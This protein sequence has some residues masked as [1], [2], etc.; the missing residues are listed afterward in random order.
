MS[1]EAERDAA[2]ARDGYACQVCGRPATQTAH[3]IPN[4]A[5]YRRL[6][7][8]RIIDSRHNLKAACSLVCNAALQV[9][10][11]GPVALAR[12]VARIEAALK[13]DGNDKS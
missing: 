1:Y 5:G 9:R 12:E 13:E 10:V 2:L 8:R 4:R 7:G 6:Y 3:G 11:V